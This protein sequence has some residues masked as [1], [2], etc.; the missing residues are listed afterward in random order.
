MRIVPT[1]SGVPASVVCSRAVTPS[2]N[3]GLGLINNPACTRSFTAES[4][5]PTWLLGLDYKPSEDWLIYA[6]YA[7][8]YRG[9]GVNE[10][11]FGVE[12]WNPEKLN[13]YEIGVKASFNGAVSGNFN[14]AG[15]WNDF[16]DQQATV[17]IP[18][19]TNAP[20]CAPTG[21][22]GIQNVG[23]SRIKGVEIDATVNLFRDLR[24][25][26]GYAYLDAVV[27]GGSVPFCDSTRFLC[28]QAAFLTAG[29][30]LLFAPKNR[31]TMSASYALPVDESVGK[32]S[33]GATFVYTDKQFQTR[34][35]AAAFAAGVLQEDY[36]LLPSTSLLNLNLNWKSVAGSPVD[37]SVYATNITGEKYRVAS[38]GG[39]A[40]TGG[41][42]I[43]VG[44]PRMYGVRLKY[45]F[46]R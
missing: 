27:T 15:F 20:T 45:N 1:A 11:N 31:F 7:R 26:F 28:A 4:N 46:G 34:G 41:E 30:Q 29:S 38:A 17:S 9:G 13:T 36:G 19:C 21:I 23:K 32:I 44:E 40:S 12:S 10:A 33:I 6:K 42:F 18:A 14:I 22:N 3:P 35:N 16:T 37:L 5:R 43:L 25:D 2:P 8:G 39:L 24:L